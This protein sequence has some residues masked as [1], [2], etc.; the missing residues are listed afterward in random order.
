M[1]TKIHAR[2]I[3]FPAAVLLGLVWAAW[4]IVAMVQAGQ[5]SAWIAWG[6][7]D[8]VAT[9]TIMVW[10]YDNTG[11]SVFAVAL[12]HA[13]ANLSAKTVFPGGSYH[14]EL[15]VS[16]ILVLVAGLVAALWRVR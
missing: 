1:T 16:V 5:S 14:G 12:Y 3:V 4:H 8:M 10:I 11:R 15:V 13:M 6:C 2:V 9:R 7:L